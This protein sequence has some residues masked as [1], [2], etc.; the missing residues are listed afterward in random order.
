MFWKTPLAAALVAPLILALPAMAQTASPATDAPVASAP[1]AALDAQIAAYLNAYSA[2]APIKTGPANGLSNAGD[3]PPT[4]RAVHGE[5]GVGMGTGGYREFHGSMVA[6]VGQ[7][8]TVA[9]AVGQVRGR[10]YLGPMDLG[11]GPAVDEGD[12]TRAGPL[13]AAADPACPSAKDKAGFEPAWVLRMRKN[14]P[15]AANDCPTASSA[16]P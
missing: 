8:G 9:I 12:L 2:N 3:A 13:R 6:P 5:V 7:T 14:E 4:D 10:G 11:L 1:D 15:A 16:K